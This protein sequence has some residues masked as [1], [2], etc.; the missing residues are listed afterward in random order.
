MGGAVCVHVCVHIVG[1][2]HHIFSVCASLFL[3]FVA[4]CHKI[5]ICHF[6]LPPSLSAQFR[7]LKSLVPMTKS[8]TCPVSLVLPFQ[9]SITLKP[10]KIAQ[11]LSR[12]SSDPGSMIRPLLVPPA[13]L[14]HS[15]L[16]S[17]SCL[18]D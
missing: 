12:A 11:Y 5:I 18:H 3:Y 8:A 2:V 14:I 15:Y 7:P 1:I 17:M 6:L 10:E 13:P 16:Y 9:C 4:L